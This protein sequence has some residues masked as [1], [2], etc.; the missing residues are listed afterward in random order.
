[1]AEPTPRIRVA[2]LLLQGGSVLLVRHQKGEDTYWLLPGGG[3]QY[4][5]SLEEAL[6]REL[7]EGMRQDG[8]PI[9]PAASR[10]EY[11]DTTA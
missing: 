10:V 4:G 7:L 6:N 11:V 9:P 8:T 5:E 2:G 1:M 3:V